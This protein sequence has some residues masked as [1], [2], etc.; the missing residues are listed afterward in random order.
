M[1][2]KP[3]LSAP[4]ARQAM[5]CVV[6]PNGDLASKMADEDRPEFRA[7]IRDLAL[8]VADGERRPG[9]GNSRRRVKHVADNPAKS[10]IDRVRAERGDSP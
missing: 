1:E 9:A 6:G 7:Y 10:L 3:A 5:A 8:R 2:Q 4:L